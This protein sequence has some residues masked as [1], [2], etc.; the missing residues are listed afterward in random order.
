L[1]REQRV[2]GEARRSHVRPESVVRRKALWSAHDDGVATTI[3]SLG[4]AN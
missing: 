2:D 4:V 1:K 3:P